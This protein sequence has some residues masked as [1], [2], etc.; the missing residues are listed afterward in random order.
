M[1]RV[2]VRRRLDFGRPTFVVSSRDDDCVSFATL[3]DVAGIGHQPTPLGS[4]ALV[5]IDCQN[6]Y[7]E[8]V[9]QLVDAEPA[10]AEVARLL[11][12]ARS[13]GSPGFHIIHDCG[14]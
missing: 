1:T 4:S 13:L 14:R 11:A 7:R 5:V 3:L 8:G 6:T 9:M 10:L 12:H 2:F